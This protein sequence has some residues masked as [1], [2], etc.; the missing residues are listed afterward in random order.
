MTTFVRLKQ[1][2]TRVFRSSRFKLQLMAAP[3]NRDHLP[4][5]MELD[6][7]L[8]FHQICAGAFVER[9]E[10]GWSRSSGQGRARFLEDV[11]RELE[12]LCRVPICLNLTSP[13]RNTG[14]NWLLFA[15]CRTVFPASNT[16]TSEKT[17]GHSCCAPKYASGPPSCGSFSSGSC[18]SQG[19]PSYGFLRTI[20]TSIVCPLARSLSILDCT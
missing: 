3:G 13:Q 18:G 2:E 15:S 12:V 5:G 14:I 17:R 20:L 16:Q 8:P 11:Q 19:H 4:L 9:G 6:I 1:R 10:T 7:A